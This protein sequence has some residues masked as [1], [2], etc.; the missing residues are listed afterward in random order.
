MADQGEGV[1]RQRACRGCNA[2]FCICRSCDR[3][4]RYCGPDCRLR[5]L[6]EQCRRANRRHQNSAE[7]RLD[8]RDRQRTYRKRCAQRYWA[9]VDRG[10]EKLGASLV[11]DHQIGALQPASQGLDVSSSS[12]LIP[13]RAP[14]LS[15]ETATAPK[16]VTDT[17][18]AALAGSSMIAAWNSGSAQLVVPS[19]SAAP[20]GSFGS[21]STGS[22]DRHPAPRCILC[23][24]RG[25]LVDPF[26]RGIKNAEISPPTAST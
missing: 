16:N 4:Q 7:G 20:I 6:R 9:S 26:S 8:H 18:S 11:T 12:T 24:R 23:G 21:A 3:G 22:K 25:R 1:F 19:S 10:V 5:V 15:E 13:F 17:S 2:V 14:S